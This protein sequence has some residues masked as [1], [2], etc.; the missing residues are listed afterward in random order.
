MKSE[1]TCCILGGLS[2]YVEG[3]L[4]PPEPDIGIY[5]YYLDDYKLYFNTGKPGRELPNAMYEKVTDDDEDEIECAL[6]SGD[7]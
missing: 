5:N 3:N 6:L 7:G 2:V 4:C 1:G